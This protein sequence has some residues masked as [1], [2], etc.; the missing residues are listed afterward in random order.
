MQVKSTVQSY[1][2]YSNYSDGKN[3]YTYQ[4]NAWSYS[5]IPQVLYNVY[6]STN[7]KWYV[8]AGASCNYLAAQENTMRI[9]DPT[10]YVTTQKDYF[11]LRIFSLNP[12]LTSG[13]LVKQRIHLGVIWG[14]PVE[15][16]DD[17]RNISIKSGLLA[18]SAAYSLKK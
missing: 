9:K 8:G 12:V 6:F 14:S 5:F 10:N 3:E 1:Y 7:L 16:A 11:G 2:K 15:Y 17:A 4:L 13:V 18:L